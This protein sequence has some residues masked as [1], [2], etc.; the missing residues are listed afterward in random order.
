MDSTTTQSLLK[1]ARVWYGR[2]RLVP[3][4]RHLQ[5]RYPPSRQ[6]I[7]RHYR[8]VDSVIRQGIER[9]GC[10]PQRLLFRTRTGRGCLI[11]R[12]QQRELCLQQLPDKEFG[13]NHS[14]GASNPTYWTN[15][16]GSTFSYMPAKKLAARHFA[17]AKRDFEWFEVGLAE[18]V[19]KWRSNLC[20][21]WQQLRHG[22]AGCRQGKGARLHIS[23]Q[24]YSAPLGRAVKHQSSERLVAYFLFRRSVEEGTA[25]I[26]RRAASLCEDKPFM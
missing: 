12:N 9:R 16:S 17:P 21:L 25:A 20:L 10:S 8:A 19:A 11:L 7:R 26:D 4:T 3:V 15:T 13:G 2:R 14:T 22:M 6:S 18:A 1:V 5:L 23:I 24:K